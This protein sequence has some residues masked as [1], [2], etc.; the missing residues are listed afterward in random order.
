MQNLDHNSMQINNQSKYYTNPP[1]KIAYVTQR[2]DV[3]YCSVLQEC[4][5]TKEYHGHNVAK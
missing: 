1:N 4:S 3:H 2:F 5:L